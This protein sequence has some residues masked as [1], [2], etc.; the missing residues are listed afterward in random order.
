MAQTVVEETTVEDR[1]TVA[2]WHQLRDGGVALTSQDIEALA[3]E[4]GLDASSV[5]R[6]LAAAGGQPASAGVR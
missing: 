4:S 5:A 2:V 3:A 6:R 1:F